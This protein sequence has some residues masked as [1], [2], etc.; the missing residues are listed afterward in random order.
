MRRYGPWL[1]AALVVVSNLAAWRVAAL[2][3]RG[4]PE[5][6]LVLTER[7]LG[8]PARQVENTA[9]TLSL[10]FEPPRQARE[11]LRAPGWFD[12]A[13][14]EAIG[15]DCRRPVTS[16]H[17][18]YYRTRLPRAA[19]AALAFGAGTS[20]DSHLVPID[21]DNDPAALR[22]RHP[23][24]R[25]VAIVEATVALQYVANAGQPP[26]LMGRVTSVL[27]SEINVP[28]EWR[29]V[30]EGLQS[31]AGPGTRPP[32][33]HEPRFRATIAWGNRLE[34]WITNVELLPAGTAR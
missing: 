31:D 14:L 2:N 11:D 28:R 32:L 22:A 24:T 16:E 15:F 26:F 1:A 29:G 19:Y 27:P 10:V 25:A 20:L 18:E 9:L 34:P 17:A 23:D 8:L 33:K 21:V 6:V 30:I 13:M 5:A 7:E 4:E 3:R 12:R